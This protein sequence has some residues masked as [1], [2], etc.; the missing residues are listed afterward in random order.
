MSRHDEIHRLLDQLRDA[1]PELRG[2]LVAST[3]GLAIAHS[4]NEQIDVDRVAAMAAT[5][6]GVGKR[7]AE[8]LG[9]GELM[10]T[11]VR[12]TSGQIF[13]YAAGSQA[14]LAVIA[15]ELTNVGLVHLEAR[16]TAGQIGPVIE[17]PARTVVPGGLTGGVA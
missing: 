17:G 4:M 1:V 13:L 9:A 7:I 3:D 16:G 6:L 15:P 11:N 14:I 2:V 12:G 5:A 10:E 8:T